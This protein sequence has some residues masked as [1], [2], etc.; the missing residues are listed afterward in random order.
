MHLGYE[1]PRQEYE[2]DG[3]VL[4]ET[5]KE[6]D[7]GVVIDTPKFSRKDKSTK[8]LNVQGDLK[9]KSCDIAEEGESS[10]KYMRKIDSSSTPIDSLRNG[11]LWVSDFSKQLW[12]EQQMEYT[13]LLPKSV[14][15]ELETDEAKKGTDFHLARELEVQE[16][17]DIK[18]ESNEDIFAVKVLNLVI[19]LKKLQRQTDLVHREVPIFGLVK[20]VFV[21]GK[22]DEIRMDDV[23]FTIDIV[24]LKTRKF[25]ALPKKSQK[26]THSLQL[27]IYKQL[28]DDLVRGLLP[29]HSMSK[30]LKLDLTKALG[31]DIVKHITQDMRHLEFPK[32]P[33]GK[34][35]LSA[36]LDE[37]R[38]TAEGLPFISRLFN[39]YVWQEDGESF[40]MD[41][42]KYDDQWLDKQVGRCISYWTG[43]REASG[44]DVEDAWKC[45]SCNFQ[46]DCS[47][48]S[49]KLQERK[50]EL[51]R[52]EDEKKSDTCKRTTIMYNN[53]DKGC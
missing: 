5:S 48:I 38:A 45:H 11:Y 32:P 44:V 40:A 18:V 51:K 53:K 4:S 37:T 13:Y 17:V 25:K 12:C 27:M 1:N 19:A 50:E 10:K 20:G 24:D 8:D 29:R 21:I 3:T 28:F 43:Q 34:W 33:E 14:V 26:A 31:A 15:K 36:L 41:E 30:I 16:Y 35:H 22:I 52:R 42:I 46:D 39:E 49:K 23:D 47:W 2:L 7:L 9:R 6:R